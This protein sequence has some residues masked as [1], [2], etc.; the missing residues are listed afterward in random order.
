MVFL[1]LLVTICIVLLSCVGVNGM[2]LRCVGDLEMT[3]CWEIWWQWQMQC[4]DAFGS[5]NVL[6]CSILTSGIFISPSVLSCFI[7]EVWFWYSDKILLMGKYAPFHC[8]GLFLC[9]KLTYSLWRHT[10]ARNFKKRHSQVNSYYFPIFVKELRKSGQYR[11][12]LNKLFP[13]Y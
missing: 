7:Y 4:I 5:N 12:T 3:K 9:S 1:K 2:C 6:L 8:Q 13:F 10:F 11:P